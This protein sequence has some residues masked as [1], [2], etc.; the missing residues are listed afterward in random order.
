M[1]K[2]ITLVHFLLFIINSFY[3]FLFS[4]NWFDFYYLLLIFFTALTWTL[5]KGECI[6]SVIFKKYKDPTYQIGENQ[7]VDDLTGIF[8]EKYKPYMEYLNKPIMAL[9]SYTIYLVLIRNQLNGWYAILYFFYI[10]GLTVT[11]NIFYQGFS[12]FLFLYIV[13]KII[14]KLWK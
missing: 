9:Q 2:I 3:A 5:C 14:H 6:I 10:L 13:I 4:K 1:E 8:G 12:F 11:T 7:S